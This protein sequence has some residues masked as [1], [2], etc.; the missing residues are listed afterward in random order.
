M[1][2]KKAYLI[3]NVVNLLIDYWPEY[4]KAAN[5]LFNCMLIKQFN[6]K[7]LFEI[8]ENVKSDLSYKYI[9]G[10]KIYTLK[11]KIFYKDWF[12]SYIYIGFLI[13]YDLCNIYYIWLF[14]FKCVMCIKDI[15]FIKDKFYK[16]DKLDLGLVENIK[17]IMKY[18]EILSSRPVLE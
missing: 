8:I 10:A 18:F 1:F 5:Y 9:Y 14:F 2:I 12:E 11:N 17:K 16:L 6:W 15:I 7:T 3:C 13:S 4:Y